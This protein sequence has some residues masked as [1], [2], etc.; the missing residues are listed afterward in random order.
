MASR[1]YPYGLVDVDMRA[2]VSGDEVEIYRRRLLSQIRDRKV[3]EAIRDEMNT[4][5]YHDELNRYAGE[6]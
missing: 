3:L 2:R 6:D 1:G 4:L 5:N